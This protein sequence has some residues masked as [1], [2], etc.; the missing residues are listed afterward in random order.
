MMSGVTAM[1]TGSGNAR[2]APRHW[3]LADAPPAPGGRAPAS[4][5]APPYATVT[6]AVAAGLAQR[7]PRQTRIQ[8]G[9]GGRGLVTRRGAGP[10]PSHG[11][12]VPVARTRMPPRLQPHSEGAAGSDRESGGGG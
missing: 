6:P 1:V 8:L 2:S 3:Y 10:S 12:T 11:G 4:R 5:R 9:P 7:G